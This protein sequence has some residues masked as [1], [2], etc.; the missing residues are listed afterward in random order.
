MNDEIIVYPDQLDYDVKKA[1]IDSMKFQ[2]ASSL[3]NNAVCVFSD[4]QITNRQID[5]A[6]KR[7]D[8]ALEAFIIDA[9]ARMIRYENGAE[10]IKDQISMLSKGI[11]KLMDKAFNCDDFNRQMMMMEQ[12]NKLTEKLT[13]LT[14]QLL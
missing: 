5:L 6:F 13:I 14:S 2:I 12:L 1:E 4:M 11:E 9:R 8:S 7:I 3:V 10:T